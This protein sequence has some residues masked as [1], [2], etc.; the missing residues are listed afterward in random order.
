MRWN[1]ADQNAKICPPGLRIAQSAL[2]SHDGAVILEMFR[3][4]RD[5]F[6]FQH[7]LG[8]RNVSLYR[9]QADVP[10]AKE[11]GL[12]LKDAPLSAATVEFHR[13]EPPKH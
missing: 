8:N 6:E 7:G 4:E 2:K 3:Y 13:E 1:S 9:Y 10:R 5:R 11:E 12:S